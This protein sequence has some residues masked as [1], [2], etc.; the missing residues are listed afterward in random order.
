MNEIEKL[1]KELEKANVV[2]DQ[3]KALIIYL[4]LKHHEYLIKHGSSK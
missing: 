3:L 1:K 4:E 2:I